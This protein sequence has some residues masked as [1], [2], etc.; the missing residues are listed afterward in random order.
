M[1]KIVVGINN[2]FF[3]DINDYTSDGNIAIMINNEI[4]FATAQE[5][6][7]RKK[8]DGGFKESLDFAFRKLNISKSDVDE[9][10]LVGFANYIDE[11]HEKLYIVKDVRNYFE[12]DIKIN[13][14]K[15]HHECHAWTA[16]VQSGFKECLIAVLDNSGSIL[17]F[18]KDRTL[19]NARVEQTSYYLYKNNELKLIHRDH[20]GFQEVGYGRLYSKVTRYIGFESYHDAGKTMGL[21]PIGKNIDFDKEKL[22]YKNVDGKEV[23]GI[24][25]AKYSDDGL[26]DLSE[27]FKSNNMRVLKGPYDN[28]INTQEQIYLS[29]WIQKSIEVSIVRQIQILLQKYPVDNICITGGVAL[30]SVMN[31]IVENVTGKNVF[32]PSSPGDAGLSIGALGYYQH[33]NKINL[34]IN[35]SPYLGIEYSEKDILAVLEKD[36][37]I[38]F[39]YVEN[40]S[41]VAA[42]L[43]YEDKIGAWFQGKSEFGPRALGNRSIISSPSNPWIK[44]VINNTVK[45][46]EWFRPFAPSVL[47]NYSDTFFETK[48]KNYNF[49]MKTT[50]AKDENKSSIPSVIHYDDSSRIQEVEEKDNH[51]YF[52][53]INNYYQLSG[54]P[55][56]L[57]TS[58]NLGGMPLVETPKDALECFIKSEL[59]DFLC[60]ENY[61][62]K[63]I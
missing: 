50:V 23:T 52:N 62:I 41:H 28:N 4:A 9:V 46:R 44:E 32:I 59:L 2:T 7:T 39:E 24:S 58:F 34:S 27:W 5:R 22:A 49:M 17:E 42:K 51:K 33:Q 12:R 55:M 31:G 3:E 14:I 60:M 45:N 8:Y 10:V 29:K 47:A 40:I 20:D 35:S 21:A 19:A 30:N 43:I 63:R 48:G 57:N 36:P 25:H 16:L 54:I 37:R 15:S 53:L 1:D 6:I 18:G 13:Y 56:V 11:D 61:L 26:L 38:Q